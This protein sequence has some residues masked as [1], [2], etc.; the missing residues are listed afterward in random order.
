MSIASESERQTATTLAPKPTLKALR[1]Q[2]KN[3]RRRAD[4]EEK[5]RQGE[6][7]PANAFMLYRR[8][9]SKEISQKYREERN[10]KMATLG[11]ADVS[12]LCGKLWRSETQHVRDAYSLAA[13]KLAKEHR[14]LSVKRKLE[15]D[16]EKEMDEEEVEESGG[17]MVQDEHT[18]VALTELENDRNLREFVGM[19]QL[20]Q[21]P[22][23]SGLNCVNANE[24]KRNRKP[25]GELGSIK[26]LNRCLDLQLTVQTIMSALRVI[27]E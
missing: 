13:T 18:M 12:R 17:E 3:T 4:R 25:E 22:Y 14:A 8:D 1:E 24:P 2:R 7:K 15:E 19:V 9:R 21:V 10:G 26:A 23:T 16:K 11:F 27:V 5:R 20:D 6:S